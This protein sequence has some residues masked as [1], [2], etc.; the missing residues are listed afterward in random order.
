MSVL[1]DILHRLQQGAQS[2]GNFAVHN[3]EQPIAQGV[4][5]FGN[6]FNNEV[7]QLPTQIQSIGNNIASTPLNQVLKYT[8]VVG[9]G[10]GNPSYNRYFPTVGQYTQ[11]NIVKP[12][13][14]GFSSIF[15]PKTTPLEKVLG[16]VQAGS[17][18]F[19]ATPIG[20]AYGAG[21]AEVSSILQGI[22]NRRNPADF[23]KQNLSSP[24]DIAGTGLGIKNPFLATPLD[25][26]LTRNP[27]SV[28]NDIKSVGKTISALKGYSPRAFNIHPADQEIMGNFVNEVQRLGGTSTQLDPQLLKDAQNIAEHY[29]GSSARTASNEKLAKAFDALLAS[30][31]RSQG[32]DALQTPFPKMG[33][34]GKTKST[35]VGKTTNLQTG[36]TIGE[37]QQATQ[38]PDLTAYE[39]AFNAGD[40]ATMNRLLALHPNDTRFQVHIKPMTPI[41]DILSNRTGT[42]NRPQTSNVKLPKQ[43]QGISEVAGSTPTTP[44]S[45]NGGGSSANTSTSVPNS[46]NPYFNTNKYN[47]SQDAKKQLNQT[48]Q[49]I[50]PQIEQAVGKPLS[51]KETIAAANASS[52]VLHKVVNRKQTADFTAKLLRTRQQLAAAADSGTVD[53]AYIDNLLAIKSQATDIARKL[54]SFNIGADPK[55]VTSRDAILEAVMKV[56]QD[57]NKITEAAKGVD[58]NDLNQATD[59]YR[60]FVKP[61]TKDWIDLIRYN[62]MLSSPTTHIVNMASNLVNNGVVAPIEKTLTG[63]LDFLGSQITG[64]KQTQFA[65]EGAVY[66]KGYLSSLHDAAHNFADSL[67]G[68]IVTGNLDVRQIPLST[69]QSVKNLN[70]PTRLLEASDQ[71]FQKLTQGAE[72]AA[73]QYRKSKGVNVGNIETTALGNAQYRL[74]RSELHRAGQGTVLNAIDDFTGLIQKAR[75]SDN[76]VTSTI[77]KFTLPF[78]QTPM[79]IL[80]QGIEYSPAGLLTLPG[81]ANKTEQLSKAIMGSAAA[82]ATAMLVASGRTTWAEPTDPAKKAAFRAAGLQPYAVKIGNNWVS[83]AKLPPALGFPIAFISAIH[84]AEQN[85]TIDQNQVDVILNAAAKYGNFFADQSY[86]K[87]IGDLVSA[88]K[89]SPEAMGRFVSNYPQQLIPYR[90]LFGWMAR[91]IDPYQRQANTNASFLDQQVQQ[92]M[93]QVPGLSMLTPARLDKNGEP[94]L[95]QNAAL[96]AFSPLRV[97]TENPAKKQVYDLLQ[98]K[99]LFT[100][101]LNIAKQ[102]MQQG[103]PV[104]LP[105][106]GAAGPADIQNPA[107]QQADKLKAQMENSLLD[108]RIKQTGK[109]EFDSQGNIR[110]VNDKGNLGTISLAPPTKG[111][112]I[113]AFVNRNWNVSK[114][115]DVY[116]SNVPQNMKDQAYQKLNVDPTKLEYADKAS[117][118]NDIK[119]Q[120]TESVAKNLTHEELLQRMVTGRVVGINGQQF[121]TDGVLTNLQADGLLS[122]AEVAVLKKLKLDSNGNPISSIGSTGTGTKKAQTAAKNAHL[123]LSKLFANNI[124]H[125]KPMVAADLTKI[126]SKRSPA[127]VGLKNV[128][129]ILAQSEGLVKGKRKAKTIQQVL[130]A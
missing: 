12:L 60:Q 101:N 85:K 72:T 106:A 22:R 122:K 61:S 52:K 37:L 82:A 123:A 110:Y 69:R 107:Q 99:S 20:A 103:K 39:N 89:G 57:S 76:P 40:T 93:M 59:F 75:N 74:F 43:S 44:S 7:R 15:N 4:S 92:L 1:D 100:K 114:A 51:N 104:T 27:E 105:L 77:A 24:S 6:T 48:I 68:K 128:Q 16:G 83:Y 38:S 50:K 119:T 84:D 127:N 115:L 9:P 73:L 118:S 18:I 23:L 55:A 21:T 13:T 11:G 79:N 34:V 5:N 3:I 63:T 33:I 64:K 53:K 108:T 126:L 129:A 26:L 47:V 102:Q 109:P 96:N 49:E 67:R 125:T 87:N 71:F 41:S 17:G 46:E 54:Q 120:Y 117:K 45:I 25:L 32:I 116:R 65:S 35:Q 88:A 58:F 8:P 19:N 10:L 42:N 29:I 62:S 121:A 91:L 56:E 94:I 130:G 112:G 66:A 97:T 30:H 28:G 80:K 90:A 36:K 2:V 95:N 81:A 14:E 78:V 31:A 113:D 98:Q 70:L 124:T 86:V 111:Q